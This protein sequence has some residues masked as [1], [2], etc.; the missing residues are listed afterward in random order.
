MGNLAHLNDT[1]ILAAPFDDAAL[2]VA[3]RADVLDSCGLKSDVP[4]PNRPTT[5]E[6]HGANMSAFCAHCKDEAPP[7]HP[8]HSC[9]TQN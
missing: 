5:T 6:Q 2:M 8:P 1:V 4:E 9:G 3:A 7:P